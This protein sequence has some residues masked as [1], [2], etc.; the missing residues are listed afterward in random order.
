MKAPPPLNEVRPGDPVL[1]AFNQLVRHEKATQLRGSPRLRIQRRPNGTSLVGQPGHGV[2]QHPWQPGLGDKLVKLRPGTVN[3]LMPLIEG[4]D[5]ITS[6]G[7]KLMTGP[8]AKLRSWIVLQVKVDGEKLVLVP[9]EIE[10]LHVNDLA[11]RPE[12]SGWQPLAMLI[13]QDRRTPA[14]VLPVAMHNL[15]HAVDRG[16]TGLRHFFWAV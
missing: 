14:R 9:E 3:G 1:P 13:W 5:M 4:V 6:P 10:L 12:D 2:W 8:N 11:A 15:S 16:T 7:V